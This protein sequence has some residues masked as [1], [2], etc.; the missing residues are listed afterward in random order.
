[1]VG[2]GFV[3]RQASLVIDW[4]QNLVAYPVS[5]V[6]F[7]QTNQVKPREDFEAA[8]VDAEAEAKSS[9]RVVPTQVKQTK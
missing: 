9:T 7:R 5:R 3:A 8:V 2:K 1:M 4:D 6:T